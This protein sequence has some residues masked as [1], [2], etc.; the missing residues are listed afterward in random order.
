MMSAHELTACM[1]IEHSTISRFPSGDISNPKAEVFF[2]L[3]LRAAEPAIRATGKRDD[4]RLIWV[5]ATEIVCIGGCERALRP[6]P[7]MG[8]R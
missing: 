8:I 1:G 7:L 6:V 2:A 3:L 5:A 4:A